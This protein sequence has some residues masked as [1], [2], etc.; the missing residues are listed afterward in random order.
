MSKVLEFLRASFIAGWLAVIVFCSYMVV[1]S[2]LE[3]KAHTRMLEAVW[4]EHDAIMLTQ[5]V[6]AYI[7][8]LETG[9]PMYVGDLVTLQMW[10]EAKLEALENSDG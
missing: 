4:Q 8:Y 6:D 10:M 9:K 1:L 2:G 3:Y 7:E 5:A